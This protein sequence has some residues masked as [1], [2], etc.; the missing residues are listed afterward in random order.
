VQKAAGFDVWYRVGVG[1]SGQWGLQ[2]GAVVF[3]VKRC[4]GGVVDE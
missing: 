4:V 1:R 2:K 3:L